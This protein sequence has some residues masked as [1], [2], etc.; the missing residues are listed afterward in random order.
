MGTVAPFGMMVVAGAAV[1][2]MVCW[3]KAATAPKSR[4][5]ATFT[6]AFRVALKL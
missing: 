5:L 3:P 4:R 6:A 1:K 2:L